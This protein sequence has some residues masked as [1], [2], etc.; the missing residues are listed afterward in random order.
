VADL[1][2]GHPQALEAI[3]ETVRTL[4]EDPIVRSGTV[5]F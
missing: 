3:T 5:G 2:A 1:P 4:T